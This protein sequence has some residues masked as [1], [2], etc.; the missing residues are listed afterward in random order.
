MHAAT[1]Y[2]KIA[3]TQPGVSGLVCVRAIIKQSDGNYVAGEWGNSSWPSVT[4]RGKAINPTNV[5]AVPTGTTQI[6]IGKGPDY[7]PQTITTNLSQANVTNTI[8]VAL[9]PQLDFYNR[10]WRAGDAHIHYYHGENEIT[11]SPQEVFRMCAAGGMNFASLAEEHYGATTLTRQQML[12]TWKVF[13]NSE[14]KI[15]DG[16]EEPKNQWG[17][18]V[19][20]LYDPWSIRSAIPYPWG[21]Y[22]VHEQG[23]VSY[24]VHPDRF[25]PARLYNGQ[26]AAFPL[27]NHF[28]DLPIEALAGHL[29]DAFSGVSDEPYKPI[30][31]TS[32]SKLLSMGYKIPLMCDS[33][34]CFDRI[35]NANKGLGLWMNYFQLE[36][37][38]LSRAALCNAVRKGRIMCTTGPMLSFSIDNA[39]SG[40]TLPADGAQHTLRIEASYKFNPWT[41]ASTTF[42]GTAPCQITT[43]D[44]LRNGQIIRTWNVNAAT[45]L[46]Q[47]PI[48]ESTN[49]VSYMVRCAGNESIW[50]A[51]YAS[52]I[53]FENVPRPRQP[54]VFKSL[55]QGRIYDSKTGA[56]LAGNVSC[57]RYGFTNWTINV[58]TSGLFR[59]YVPIDADLVATDATGRSFTQNIHKVESA[60]SFCHY[61]PDNYPDNKGP[62]VDAFSNLV[63]QLNYEFPIGLQLAASYVR[64][65]LSGNM[66]LTNVSILS[67]PTAT[68]GKTTTEIVMLLVDKTQVQPG[69]TINYAAIFRQPNNVTPSEQLSIVWNGWDP[70]RPHINTKYQYSFGENSG[71]AGTSIGS[72]FWMRAGSIVVPNWVTNDTTTTAAIDMFVRV[73]GSVSESGHLLLRVG[74]TK[75]ELLVSSTSDGWP[76]TWGQ[77][78][79]GPCNFYRDNANIRYADYRSMSIRVNFNGQNTTIT[80]LTDTTHVADA[81]NAIFYENFFYDGNC[82]PQYRNIPFRDAVRTQ[83]SPPNF[84]SV[85]I[86]DPPDTTP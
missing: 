74:P 61:L 11:H 25:Y 14:C 23:G 65:N 81:D 68:S 19:A 48:S 30:N 7:L 60:Y 71:T 82:E 12:D 40:D 76:A 20:I 63:Q 57:V 53:Y 86:Q 69:D 36:G 4:I 34:F 18:H 17:H 51:A 78:G 55:V 5:I 70:T 84:S 15:W 52:P 32:Y 79:I 6:T 33:D 67:A 21:V 54:P 45:T 28:K 56:A 44:L 49:N 43:I 62:A 37:N 50:V 8:S 26:Y 9:Q 58:G 85:P 75:R 83:P 2:F 77:L 31:L 72:G 64:T 38:P 59:A 47:T 39:I 80:P 46:I 73:I 10:G 29:L 13:D 1:T 3:A 66:A 24:P 42:D 16:I 27:N 41:L 22:N 35:N